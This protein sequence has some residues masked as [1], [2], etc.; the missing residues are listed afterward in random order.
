MGK[1]DGFIPSTADS[2]NR[3]VVVVVLLTATFAHISRLLSAPSIRD[4]TKRKKSRRQPTHAGLDF[5]SRLYY[6]QV[7]KYLSTF[8]YFTC[9][10][11]EREQRREEMR[12]Q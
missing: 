7:T 10:L 8:T 1:R 6:I 12:C 3:V 2:S 5:G 9:S 11:A 4:K